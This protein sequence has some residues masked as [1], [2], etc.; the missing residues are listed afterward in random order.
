MNASEP[1]APN[2]WLTPLKFLIMADG[3]GAVAIL[4]LVL[5]LK[6]EKFHTHKDFHQ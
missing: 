5:H 3:C 4:L 1:V 2:C 6:E